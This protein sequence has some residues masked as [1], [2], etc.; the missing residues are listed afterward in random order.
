M[1]LYYPYFN[2][3]YSKGTTNYRLEVLVKMP[4]VCYKEDIVQKFTGDYWEVRIKLREKKESTDGDQE[5]LEEYSIELTPTKVE[6]LD[7]IKIIV[8]NYDNH[9]LE[10]TESDG[11]GKTGSGNGELD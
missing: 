3:F 4:A 6:E 9:L 10:E 1:K 7:K 2:L 8:K 5:K 11:E